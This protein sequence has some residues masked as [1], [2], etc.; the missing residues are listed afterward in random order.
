MSSGVYKIENIVNGRIYIGSSK[1]LKK[2]W[3]KHKS[4]LRLNRHYS[5]EMQLDYNNFGEKTFLFQILETCKEEDLLN[6]EQKYLNILNPFY[7]L[8][9][10]AGS[11]LGIKF[12]EN[13]KQIISNA[14][15][16][17]YRPKGKNNPRSKAIIQLDINN[18]FLARFDNARDIERKL[19]IEHSNI[20][21]CCKGRLKS[22]GGYKWLYEDDYYKLAES[23]VV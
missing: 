1:D 16:G 23:E 15:K 4:E 6:I 8:C 12:S 5:K 13:H 3:W 18:S 10:Y 21:S 11:P 2:R 22:S 17:I 19:N 7:N 14:L 9:R 20:I